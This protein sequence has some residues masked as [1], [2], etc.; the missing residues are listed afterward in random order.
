V[1]G[2]PNQA[3]GTEPLY[4]ELP[5]ALKYLVDEDDRANKEVVI[6]ALESELGVATEDSVAVLERR[7]A[8]LEDRLETEKDEFE[9]RRDR[10]QDLQ[11]DLERAREVR[12]SKQRDSEEYEEALDE[13]LDSIV[14][15]EPVRCFPEHSVLDD[16]AREF[17]KPNEETHLDLQQRAAETGRDLSV[18][19]FKD[20]YSATDED[21]QT[22]IAEKWPQGGEP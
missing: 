10:V 17:G 5:E 14:D 18:G 2:V 9:Y 19:N 20:A 13:L 11:E 22:P 15:G 4:V 16:L 12:D 3:D 1:V 7:I 8:R 21:D 6:A